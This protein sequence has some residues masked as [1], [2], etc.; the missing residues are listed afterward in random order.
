MLE[1]LAEMRGRPIAMWVGQKS[2]TKLADFLHGYECALSRFGIEDRFRLIDLT[3]WLRS[4][5][6]IKSSFGWS[7]I[8]VHQSRDD[9]DAVDNFW[10]LLDEYLASREDLVGQFT[11]SAHRVN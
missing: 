11:V 10:K 4:R 6:H 5:F 8:I 2:L 7:T 9:A 3:E 1:L